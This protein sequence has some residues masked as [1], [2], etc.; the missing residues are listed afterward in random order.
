MTASI[1]I[2]E[3]GAT[4]AGNVTWVPTTSYVAAKRGE[5]REVLADNV[6]GAVVGWNET[7]DRWDYV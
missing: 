6:L 7:T 1:S 2:V 5:F 3:G 4:F